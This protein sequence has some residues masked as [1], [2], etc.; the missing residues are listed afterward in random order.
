VMWGTLGKQNRRPL[1]LCVVGD[2]RD[3]YPKS[4]DEDYVGF[5]EAGTLEV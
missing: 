2:I 5:R 1:P 4:K 3:A